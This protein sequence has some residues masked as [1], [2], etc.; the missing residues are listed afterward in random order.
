[1]SD[2]AT[3]LP[4]PRLTA[5]VGHWR[6]SGHVIG[7]PQVPVV[8]TDIYE[9]FAGGHFLVHHVDVTVGGQSVRAI[10]RLASRRNGYL[11]R[12]Y[13]SDATPKSCICALTMTAC[14]TSLAAARLRRLPNRKTPR[15]LVSD[16]PSPSQGPSIDGGTV[17]TIRRRH[18][19]AALDGGAFHQGRVTMVEHTGSAGIPLRRA[20]GV[21]VSLPTVS[22]WRKSLSTTNAPKPPA[23][24]HVRVL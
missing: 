22:P 9:L 23:S 6:T 20:S 19:V 8:G 15:L 16:R 24:N 13:D 10:E 21:A 5:I 3:R 11:G 1:M 14:S 18:D 17:G 4:D 2:T 7:D 12:S